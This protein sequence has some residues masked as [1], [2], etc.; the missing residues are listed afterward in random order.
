MRHELEVLEEGILEVPLVVAPLPIIEGEELSHGLAPIT[1]A[2]GIKTFFEAS[3][4]C[5]SRHFKCL[6]FTNLNTPLTR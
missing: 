5:R 2:S 1:F 6:N 3:T 4:C